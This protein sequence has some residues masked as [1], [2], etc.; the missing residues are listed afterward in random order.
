MGSLNPV[1]S[2][3]VSDTTSIHLLLSNATHISVL[4][5]LGFD[6]T[7]IYI[8]FI[9]QK[10]MV[11][12]NNGEQVVMQKDQ[13]TLFGVGQASVLRQMPLVVCL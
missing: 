4:M 1:V 11:F 6:I 9:L 5:F 2:F 13:R 10:K 8:G 12:N 3:Y 7:Y